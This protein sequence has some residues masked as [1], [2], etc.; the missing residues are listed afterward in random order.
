MDSDLSGPLLSFAIDI[1]TEVRRGSGGGNII[2][3][4]FSIA[5]ALG[6]TLA[7]AR[8][9][10][11][12]QILTA[13]H[14]ND[15]SVFHKH[16]SQLQES[17]KKHVPG[18]AV[19]LANRVYCAKNFQLLETYRALLEEM[20]A[21]TA[22][23]V[24][25]AGDSD[26]V[27][28][29][30][31]DWV[32]VVT[33]SKIKDLLPRDLITDKTVAI[34]VNAVYFKGLWDQPFSRDGTEPMEFHETSTVTTT[35][36]TMFRKGK[37]KIGYSHE[38]KATALEMPYINSTASMIVLLPNEIEGLSS[39]HESL[40]CHRL[41]QFLAQMKTDDNVYVYFPKFSLGEVVD[42]KT[43]LCQLG[44]NELFASSADLSGI[45][46]ASGFQF[47]DAV[48]KAFVEVNEESTEAAAATALVRVK[49]C[50]G[51]RTIFKA[52]HPFTFFI[53]GNDPRVVLFMGSLN[54]PSK[55]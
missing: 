19:D 32:E 8:R 3:S 29:R 52:D 34:L 50:V 13:L 35:V 30:I 49:K 21:T 14:V 47:S 25:F 33:R 54:R 23:S 4:P 27:R 53:L 17:L 48:H 11:A 26:G 31:N 1:Y 12:K 5:A 16:F 37:F 6:M 22:E 51:E 10:T 45:S 36:D 40:S 42:L 18:T 9:N 39:L 44:V 41:S 2:F 7:G 55:R 38:L 24:D 20:Y 46:A 43:V 15:D 28:Q